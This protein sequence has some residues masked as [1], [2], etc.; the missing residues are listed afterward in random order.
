[1]TASDKEIVEMTAK[2][3]AKEAVKEFRKTLNGDK[4]N[5][6][7]QELEM[8]VNN[9]IKDSIAENGK[10]IIANRKFIF[11]SIL[12]LFLVTIGGMV[13]SLFGG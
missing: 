3:T 8:V 6:R 2:L 10:G 1:M 12:G 5:D 11:W 4:H 9:G 7:I 13:I